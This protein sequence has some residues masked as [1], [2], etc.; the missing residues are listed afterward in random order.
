MPLPPPTLLEGF[1]KSHITG[2]EEIARAESAGGSIEAGSIRSTP[3]ETAEVSQGADF[4]LLV[5]VGVGK[6]IESGLDSFFILVADFF[7]LISRALYI[8]GIVP[9]LL[10][11]S[12]LDT[13]KSTK[14]PPCFYLKIQSE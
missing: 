13:L 10:F 11:E 12:Y 2:E 14:Q 8:F 9:L 5:M 1:C 4:L 7:L 3:G 6:E